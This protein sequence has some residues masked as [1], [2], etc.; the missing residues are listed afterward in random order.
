MKKAIALALVAVLLFTNITVARAATLE[1][2]T[3]LA[4]YKLGIT[5]RIN[6]LENYLDQ[7][8]SGEY[9][10][11]FKLRTL[12]EYGMYYKQLTDY[13]SL[14]G[15]SDKEEEFYRKRLAAY[16]LEFNNEYAKKTDEVTHAV[17]LKIQVKTDNL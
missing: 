9:G 3:E 16:Y 14:L 13:Q 10:L 8:V 17:R 5:T 1:N 12:N 15:F 7:D 2:D 11:L 4:E 6:E